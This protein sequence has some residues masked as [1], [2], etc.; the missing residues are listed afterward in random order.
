MLGAGSLKDIPE[1]IGY[2]RILLGL[3]MADSKDYT[4]QR[5]TDAGSFKR[6]DGLLPDPPADKKARGGSGG[7]EKP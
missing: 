2:D 1:R 3:T 4:L 7:P 5:S 6:F